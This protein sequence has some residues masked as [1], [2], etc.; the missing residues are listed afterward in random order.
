MGKLSP[1]RGHREG[2]EP[3]VALKRSGGAGDAALPTLLSVLLCSKDA[4]LFCRKF[5]CFREL[6]SEKICLQALTVPLAKAV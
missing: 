2:P 6:E 4:L 1:G 5:C 3:W